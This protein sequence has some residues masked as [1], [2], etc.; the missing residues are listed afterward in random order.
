MV[1]FS[2]LTLFIRSFLQP[3][4]MMTKRYLLLLEELIVSAKLQIH[5]CPKPLPVK[6]RS[7]H[8]KANI[9]IA[10]KGS[11]LFAGRESV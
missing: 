2:S 5:D 9:P 6:Y 4:F 11:H 3:G 1:S 10:V 8:G 7:R